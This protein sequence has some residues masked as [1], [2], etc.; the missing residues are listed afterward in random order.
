MMIMQN[1]EYGTQQ[2]YYNRLFLQDIDGALIHEEAGG[3]MLIIPEGQTWI[4]AKY[5]LG[6]TDG[7]TVLQA[8]MMYQESE[9]SGEVTDYYKCSTKPMWREE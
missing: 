9:D 6:E 4:T 2:D 8:H 3:S 5:T 1:E 7:K